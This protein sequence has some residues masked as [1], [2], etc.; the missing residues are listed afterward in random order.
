MVVIFKG[1]LVKG[2]GNSGLFGKRLN[3]I[4]IKLFENV[5]RKGA[6]TGCCYFHLFPQ[7]FLSFPIQNSVLE[8]PLQC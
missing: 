8:S 4:G 5:V 7:C 6:N 2:C 1:L 3:A